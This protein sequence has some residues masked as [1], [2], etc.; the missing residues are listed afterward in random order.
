M[1]GP[2]PHPFLALALALAMLTACEVDTGATES[3]APAEPE[4]G[5]I[6]FDLAGP[7]EAAL[8]VPVHINGE[9]PFDFVLDTGATFTCVDLELAERLALEERND[10]QGYGIA[11]GGSGA[12]QLVTLDTVRIGEASASGL[13]G[14][15]LDLTQ[16]REVGPG[17][18]GLVGLNFLREF[19]V[20]LD[21]SRNVLT[22]TQ[23]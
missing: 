16:L 9:G 18:K 13:V 22:L 7:D 12:L 8:L 23:P 15:V 2:L 1:S 6:A 20:E 21:F 4:A 10:I 11:I 17:G 5:E 14:C 19:R 3:A